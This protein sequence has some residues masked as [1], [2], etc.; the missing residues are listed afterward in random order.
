MQGPE[1][2]AMKQCVFSRNGQLGIWQEAL[3][4]LCC[5]RSESLACFVAEKPL[6]LLLGKEGSFVRNL[7]AEELAKGVDAAWRMSTDSAVQDFRARLASF[8]QVHS[9]HSDSLHCQ[10]TSMT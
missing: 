1:P 4:V 10:Q 9:F 5:T 3:T 8:V 2:A 7:L 6:E